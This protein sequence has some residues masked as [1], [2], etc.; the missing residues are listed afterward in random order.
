MY[1]PPH[2]LGVSAPPWHGQ[3]PPP[4]LPHGVSVPPPPSGAQPP[5][6]VAPPRPIAF[7]SGGRSKSAV[8]EGSSEDDAAAR[9]GAHLTASSEQ[10]RERRLAAVP[11]ALQDALRRLE[12]TAAE[13]ALAFFGLD[14]GWSGPHQIVLETEPAGSDG[15]YAEIVLKLNFDEKAWKRVRKKGKVA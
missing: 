15:S 5:A 11:S 1:P 6:P 3:P 9:D 12:P 14:E 10:Q 2:P 8:E 13:P 4:A 7:V